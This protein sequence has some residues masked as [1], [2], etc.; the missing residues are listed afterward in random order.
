MHGGIGSLAWGLSEAIQRAGGEVLFANRVKGIRR[1]GHRWCVQTRNEDML[2]ETVVANVLPQSLATMTAPQLNGALRDVESSVESGWGAAMLYLAI[3]ARGTTC[4]A[5]SAPLMSTTAH[6][7][8]RERSLFP[9][10]FRCA[11]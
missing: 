10:T 7:A 2:T 4:S 3:D 6:R 11:S 5:P 8:I 9:P 1:D